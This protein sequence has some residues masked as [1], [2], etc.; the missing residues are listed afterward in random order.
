MRLI[1]TLSHGNA[2]VES[3]FSV[4]ADMLVENLQEESLIKQGTLY[5]LARES[6]ELVNQADI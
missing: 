2:S 4:N 3:G 1:L 6:G 5:D